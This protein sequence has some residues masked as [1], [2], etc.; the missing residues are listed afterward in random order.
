MWPDKRALDLLKIERRIASLEKERAALEAKSKLTPG[1]SG[2]LKAVDRELG[3]LR[4]THISVQEYVRANPYQSDIYE[5]EKVFAQR[6]AAR[7]EMLDK[8][9]EIAAQTGGSYKDS[10]LAYVANWKKRVEADHAPATSKGKD[11]EQEPT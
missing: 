5:R 10:L 1:R 2:Q 7:Q 9:K 6:D 4:L 3:Q 11:D 8:K